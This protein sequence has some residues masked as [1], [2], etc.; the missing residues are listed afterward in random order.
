MWH[1]RLTVTVAWAKESSTGHE[2]RCHITDISLLCER[3][4]LGQP[5]PAGN[6][7]QTTATNCCTRVLPGDPVTG[8]TGVWVRVAYRSSDDPRVAAALS[9]PDTG[10]GELQAGALIPRHGLTGPRICSWQ[11]SQPASLFQLVLSF[12]NP[13]KRLVSLL[14]FS[15]PRQ[16]KSVSLLNVSGEENAAMEETFRKLRDSQL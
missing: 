6:P 16:A 1:C 5:T 9:L 14:S 12:R 7:Q 8:V 4:F 2:R 15:V 11:L 10:S 3:L 13:E